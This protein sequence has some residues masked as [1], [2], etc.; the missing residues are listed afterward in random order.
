MFCRGKDKRGVFGV[1]FVLFLLLFLF[2]LL[3]GDKQD[4]ISYYI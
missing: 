2:V 1:S 4:S 3:L